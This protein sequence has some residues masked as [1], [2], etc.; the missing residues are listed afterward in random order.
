MEFSCDDFRRSSGLRELGAYHS[1][2]PD[3]AA[4]GLKAPNITLDFDV[5][6]I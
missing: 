2:P 6:Y 4:E 5:L 1:K 3:K